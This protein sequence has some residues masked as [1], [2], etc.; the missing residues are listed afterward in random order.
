MTQTNRQLISRIKAVTA[1][2]EKWD[3]ERADLIRRANC[4]QSSETNPYRDELHESNTELEQLGSELTDA[5][6]NASGQVR[7]STI[8]RILDDGGLA[9]R[10]RL[11]HYTI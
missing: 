2:I 8:R 4:F 6:D 9:R 1:K 3:E 7:P 5:V 10:F 11:E